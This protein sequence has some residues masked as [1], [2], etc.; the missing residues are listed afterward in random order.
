MQKQAHRLCRWYG[1]YVSI[2]DRCRPFREVANRKF[3]SHPFIAKRDSGLE[4]LNG[5]NRRRSPHI[6]LP[7]RIALVSLCSANS[8]SPATDD[9]DDC[10]HDTDNRDNRKYKEDIADA[11]RSDPRGNCKDYNGRKCVADKHNP[12]NIVANDL[13]QAP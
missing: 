2:V 10:R 12:N 11:N 13:G 7:S 3:L 9:E 5:T 1:L 4:T 6:Q 8:Q